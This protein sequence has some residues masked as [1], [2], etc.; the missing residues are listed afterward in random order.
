MVFTKM[1][2]ETMFGLTGAYLK[3][4]QM[5]VNMDDEDGVDEELLKDTLDSITDAIE[6]KADGYKAVMDDLEL[7]AAA[8]DGEIQQALQYVDRLKRRKASLVRNVGRLKD[9][10]A[11][12]ME[13]IG[14]DKIKT[15]KHTFWFQNSTSVKAPD[16]PM[17]LPPRYIKHKPSVDKKLL[18]K[19]LKAGVDV[20]NASLVTTKTLRMN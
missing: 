9:D 18:G 2:N 16:D 1:D 11:T 13:Q 17:Q 19:D 7:K 8:L 3:V 12:A 10:L 14:R 15:D 5:L 4:Y 6:V 20:P